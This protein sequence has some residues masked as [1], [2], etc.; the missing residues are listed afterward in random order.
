M[1][2]IVGFGGGASTEGTA[3]K[4]TKDNTEWLVQ[5]R[6][7]TVVF[8]LTFL[9]HFYFKMTPATVRNNYE[10]IRYRP[11]WNYYSNKVRCVYYDQFHWGHT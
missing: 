5:R 7:S 11:S 3:E 6:D 1:C 10:H 2:I 4:N 8:D 9:Y